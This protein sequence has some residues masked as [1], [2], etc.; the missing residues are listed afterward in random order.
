MTMDTIVVQKSLQYIEITSASKVL[1]IDIW[2]IL[3]I[4]NLYSN[5]LPY[6]CSSSPI[7]MPS[8]CSAMHHIFFSLTHELSP[9]TRPTNICS[10]MVEMELMDIGIFVCINGIHNGQRTE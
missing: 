3:Y 4:H 1:T 10:I 7:G 2:S 5:D 6:M 9:S 8:D